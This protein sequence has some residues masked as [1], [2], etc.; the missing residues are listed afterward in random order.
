[1]NED[2]LRDRLGRL[3]PT[4]D[5]VA[6]EPVTTPSSR[7]RLEQIMNTPSPTNPSAQTE[8]RNENPTKRRGL[9][10][11]AAAVAVVA[12]L[13][14]ASI[15]N[16][17]NNSEDPA[18][19]VAPLEL[20]FGFNDPAASCLRIDV[21][22]LAQMTLA[23]GGTA[24]SIDDDRITVEVDRWYVGGDATTVELH[25]QPDME[26]LI[27]GFAFETGEEY[28]ITATNG[29]VNYCGYSGPATPDYQAL[30]DEAFPA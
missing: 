22:S 12:A 1:V 20:E 23:F 6:V 26:A 24:T 21:A 14:I 3:D 8:G 11:A 5:D 13:G 29:S 25:A 10:V 18:E 7:A 16:S 30:F 19:T 28:L 27:A 9:F 15:I 4:P 2:H 17:D